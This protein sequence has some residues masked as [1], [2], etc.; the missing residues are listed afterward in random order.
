MALSRAA[1]LLGS[2][3]VTIANL[4]EVATSSSSAL[5]TTDIPMEEWFA[6]RLSLSR[7]V[8]ES[9]PLLFGWGLTTRLGRARAQA[10]EQIKWLVDEAYRAGHTDAWTIGETRHPSRWHQYTADLHGRT[11]GG[12]SE[13]RLLEVLELRPLRH[14]YP[15]TA[16]DRRI[17][18]SDSS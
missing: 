18:L 8:N 1:E 3:G 11:S 12:S 13:A 6:S 7:A 4:V 2:R 17:T 14:F 15:G 9:D 5:A 10:E 16:A